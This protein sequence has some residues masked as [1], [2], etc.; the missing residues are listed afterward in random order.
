MILL[1][2]PSLLFLFTLHLI[3]FPFLSIDIPS[4][5]ADKFYNWGI[6]LWVSPKLAST[7]FARWD[8]HL[9]M[10]GFLA[11]GNAIYFAKHRYVFLCVCVVDCVGVGVGVGVLFYTY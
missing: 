2:D 6:W 10:L 11:F 3:S 5:S 1:F 9:H 4:T 7:V 8:I